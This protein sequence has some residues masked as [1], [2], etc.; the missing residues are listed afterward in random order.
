MDRKDY[1][2]C[3][4]CGDSEKCEIISYCKNS[5]LNPIP[6]MRYCPFSGEKLTSDLEKCVWV[7]LLIN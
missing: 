5:D 6:K 7:K 1:F 2:I 4:D 3:N